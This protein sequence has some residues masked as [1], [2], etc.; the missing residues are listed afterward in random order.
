[1]GVRRTG[2]AG[3][4]TAAIAQ[5]AGLPKANLHYYFATKETLPFG[6]RTGADRLACRRLRPSTR[7]NGRPLR[8]SGR[9]GPR[10]RDAARDPHLVGGDHA[11]AR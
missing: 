8:L 4:T 10:A 2:F 6:D 9:N 1:M 11:A 7:A 3:A 5:R